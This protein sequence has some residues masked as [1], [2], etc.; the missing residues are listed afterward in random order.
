MQALGQETSKSCKPADRIAQLN[1][2]TGEPI[3]FG[4]LAT[5]PPALP[6]RKITEGDQPLEVPVHDGPVHP[7]RFGDVI[8]GPLRL[9]YEEIEQDPSAGRILQ[10]ANGPVDVGQLILSHPGSLPAER[11]GL[12]K[13]PPS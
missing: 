5:L 3:E 13:T 11:L 9:V 1:L 4:R 10:G 7:N 6:D 12:L 2:L 8:H